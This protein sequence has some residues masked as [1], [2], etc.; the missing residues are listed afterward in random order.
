MPRLCSPAH[1]NI[2]TKRVTTAFNCL[3]SRLPTG[4]LS[5]W[6]W[7]LHQP[8]LPRVAFI[9]TELAVGPLVPQ[10]RVWERKEPTA[11]NDEAASLG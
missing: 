11:H 7:G 9:M 8:F 6:E 3:H 5:F 4:G 1:Y 2:T 10:R